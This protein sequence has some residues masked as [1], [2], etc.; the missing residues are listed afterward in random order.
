MLDSFCI[1]Q[2]GIYFATAS[3]LNVRES[4]N[5]NS[6]IISKIPY[7]TKISAI[8]TS[9]RDVIENK[10]DFWYKVNPVGY[11]FG[12]FLSKTEP[13][14]EVYKLSLKIDNSSEGCPGNTAQINLFNMKAEYSRGGSCHV[15]SFNE[16]T[17][18]NYTFENNVIKIQWLAGESKRSPH[19]N[20]SNVTTKKLEPWS[21]ELLWVSDFNGW[22]TPENLKFFK[23]NKCKI[24]QGFCHYSC[25]LT[26]NWDGNEE[27]KSM[28]NA[29][30]ENDMMLGCFD[31]GAYYCITDKN[32]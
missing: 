26:D 14:K 3:I 8:K 27:E 13:K 31:E 9:N 12:T 24:S 19:S 11:V 7:G 21:E 2:H 18:G 16:T 23:E 17:K 6:N 25:A 29:C 5:T 32:D 20:P 28:Y 4:P 22:I 15:E 30:K 1:K 10:N